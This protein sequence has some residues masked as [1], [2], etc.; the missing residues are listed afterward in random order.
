MDRG[1]DISGSVKHMKKSGALWIVLFAFGAGVIMLIIGSIFSDKN[2]DDESSGTSY[3]YNREEFEAYRQE[4]GRGIAGVCS[5]IAGCE[6]EVLLNFETSGEV[7]YAQNTNTSYDGDKRQEYVI[8]GSGSNEEALYLGQKFPKLS[9]IGIISS[10][11]ISQARRDEICSFLSSAY[12]LP[13][14]RIY[15]I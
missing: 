8:I 13:L 14:T 4:L 11:S 6:V 10:G 15:V 2:R 5:K 12:G 9:G 3:T 7:I 1:Q